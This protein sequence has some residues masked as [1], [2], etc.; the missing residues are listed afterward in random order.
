MNELHPQ[1]D[2]AMLFLTRRFNVLQSSSASHLEFSKE[3]VVE[4]KTGDQPGSGSDSH[5]FIEIFG[6]RG[7][8]GERPLTFSDKLNAFERGQTDVF[9][10]TTNILLLLLLLLLLYRVADGRVSGD[11]WLVLRRPAPP[12]VPM[13]MLIAPCL[14]HGLSFID[15]RP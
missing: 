6:T 4:V 2:H 9:Q 1:A 8:S 10:V 7:S 11:Y 15:T 5:I 12:L 13:P 3:Y 14:H